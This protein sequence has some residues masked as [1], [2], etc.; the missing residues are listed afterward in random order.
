MEYTYSDDAFSDLFKDVNGYR[1]RGALMDDWRAVT[2]PDKKQEL[3]DALCDELKE[4]TK[5]ENAFAV[6]QV[7]QFKAAIETYITL[8][9][10]DRTTAL[11]WMTGTC[12]FYT[13]QCVESW[14]WDKGILFTDY[15][16]A[17]VTELCSIVKYE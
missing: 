17:L 16:K 15:G 14:I 10:G 4:N 1:P 8:G 9:A 13:G 5:R 12:T 2:D 6:A 7:D 11:R 3:W